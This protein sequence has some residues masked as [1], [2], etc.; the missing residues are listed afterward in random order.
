MELRIIH[1]PHGYYT[2][3]IDGKFYGNYDT[4]SEAVADYESLINAEVS[5]DI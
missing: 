3:Y 5:N 2:M 4:V 1:D